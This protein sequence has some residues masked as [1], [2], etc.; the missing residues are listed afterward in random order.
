[1]A[2]NVSGSTGIQEYRWYDVMT[3]GSSLST[4]SVFITPS[5]NTT[6]S[7]YVSIYDPVSGEESNRVASV[8]SV[9]VLAKP[10]LS[11]SGPASICAGT[12]AVI[13]APPGFTQYIWSSGETTQQLIVKAGGNYSVQVG[14]GQCLSATSDPIAVVVSALP[15][16]PQ[17]TVTGS[18]TF[19]GTGSVDLSGP[20]GF[21]YQWSNGQTTQKITVSE[22]NVITLLVKN[23]LGCASAL[24]EPIVVTKLLPPCK[25]NTAPII[26]TKH[27]EVKIE[28]TAVVDL[29][30]YVTDA[31]DNIDYASLRLLIAVTAQGAP[32]SIDASYHLTIDY[33]G[34]Q[35][36][37]E[38]RIT[39]EVYDLMG[40]RAQR[41]M[42]IDVA[43]EVV[44]FN[45]ITPDGDGKNDM[46]RLQYVDVIPGAQKNKVTIFNR[47]GDSVF[48]I[49]DYNNIDRVF[50][51]LSNGGS[52]LPSGSY[53]YRIDLSEGKPV[54]GFITLKR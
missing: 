24:S 46:L 19:C 21:Q 1:V 51:G 48:E 32:A 4:S 22:S 47:W 38:D 8:A 54:T 28:G 3:G 17:I 31:E 18:A 13:S 34:I 20:D 50:T 12:S 23:I 6:S 45:G 37:G 29:T 30:D 35:F 27:I 10:V 7:Y 44:V 41:V 2:L 11:L 52:E 40:L 5:L 25:P 39:M 15:A 14:D 53:F 43:G 16:K 42:E 9:V 49:T 26:S 33:A 36:S